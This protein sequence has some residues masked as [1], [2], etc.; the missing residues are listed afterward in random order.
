MIHR[1]QDLKMAPKITLYNFNGRGRAEM[2][3]TIMAVGNIE[4]ENRR[5]SQEEWKV[6]KPSK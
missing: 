4:Y 2:A 1:E 3:R 5:M 6:V